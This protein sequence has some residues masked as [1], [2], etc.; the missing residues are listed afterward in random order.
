MTR[1]HGFF[2][3]NLHEIVKGSDRIPAS[4][5]KADARDAE[6]V[7]D[8]D[9]FVSVGNLALAIVRAGINKILVD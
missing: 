9:A 6:F 2:A 8:F 7:G 1:E 4:G 3:P 5:I